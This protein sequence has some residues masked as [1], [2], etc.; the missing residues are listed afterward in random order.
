MILW[1]L[2]LA[3]SLLKVW[4]ELTH[5]NKPWYLASSQEILGQPLAGGL[6]SFF[7]FLIRV[8]IKFVF[9]KDFVLKYGISWLPFL[10]GLSKFQIRNLVQNSAACLMVSRSQKHFF[11]KLHCPKNEGK[12]RQYS[13]LWSYS[14]IL[15]DIS[16]LFWAMVFQEKNVLRFTDC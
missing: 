2:Y 3:W 14:R 15:S 5:N 8:K 12:I 11:L 4:F 9:L 1:L 13:A 16:F 10:S 6:H 7:F